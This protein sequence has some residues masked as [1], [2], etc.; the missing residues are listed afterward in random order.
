MT[1]YAVGPAAFEID[2]LPSQ[3][4]VAICH[5][6]FVAPEARG[7][8]IAHQAK[9][10]QAEILKGLAYDYAIC[11]VMANNDAQKRVLE[12][13]GWECIA[14]FYSARQDAQI[15]I[16]GYEINHGGNSQ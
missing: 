14:E 7:K 8:G 9:K 15:E 11:T 2:S 5:G 6:F 13:A 12:K 16:W 10:A 1:R 4:Q 3:C